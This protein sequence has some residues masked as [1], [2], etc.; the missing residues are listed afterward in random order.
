[1]TAVSAEELAAI[2]VDVSH[3]FVADEVYS[4]RTFIPA[5]ASLTKHS[6]TYDH[7]SGLVRGKVVL[8]VDGV[9]SEIEG[10]KMLLIKA[11][12]TH[13]IRAITDSVWHC[14][15]LTGE[16]DPSK[17]DGVLMGESE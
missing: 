2:G 1:M 6:H 14:I 15:H 12:S 16:T 5:G 3:H 17:V 7:A 11:G 4:K 9:A 13:S 8:T 10:S